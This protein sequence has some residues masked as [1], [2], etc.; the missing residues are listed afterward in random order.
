MWLCE[1]GGF[2]RTKGGS[3]ELQT[4]RTW[5]ILIYLFIMCGI[6]CSVAKSCMTLC[7][8]LNCNMPRFPV[9]HY[10]S[11]FVKTHV[12]WASDAIQPSHPQLPP[13]VSSIFPSIRVILCSTWDLS[14][15]TKNWTCAPCI[16]DRSLNHW[17]AREVSKKIILDDRSI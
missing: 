7:N 2:N 17:T 11:E 5:K 9:L 10:L 8:Y 13:L 3:V 6:C 1:S 15:L 16:E 4:D 14:S 12:H